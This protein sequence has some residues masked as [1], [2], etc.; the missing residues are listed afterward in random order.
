[1]ADGHRPK[2]NVADHTRRQAIARRTSKEVQHADASREDPT[3]TPTA[4]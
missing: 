2:D 4:K 3:R 1:M